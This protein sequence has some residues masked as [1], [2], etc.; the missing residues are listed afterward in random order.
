MEPAAREFA[1]VLRSTTFGE[2]HTPVIANVTGKPYPGG[3]SIAE[4]LAEQITGSVQWAQTVCYLLD[5]GV[6]EFTEM[7]PGNVLTRLVQEIRKA[8]RPAAELR[9]ADHRSGQACEPKA[10]QQ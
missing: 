1:S 2:L 10:S 9:V 7:G 4:L 6:T 8:E 3:S 5:Q